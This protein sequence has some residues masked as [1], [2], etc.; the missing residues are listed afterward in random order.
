MERNAQP[1][2]RPH[3]LGTV[4][5]RRRHPDADSSRRLAGLPPHPFTRC[6]RP[7]WTG[8]GHTSPH[9]LTCGRCPCRRIRPAQDAAD[10]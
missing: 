8:P 2:L 3:V 6:P 7:H 1:Q 4:N 5:L 9:L 10:H